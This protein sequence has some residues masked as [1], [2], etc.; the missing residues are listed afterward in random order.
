MLKFNEQIFNKIYILNSLKV[1]EKKMFIIFWQELLS[2][3]VL[4]YLPCFAFLWQC[5][6]FIIILYIVL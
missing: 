3:V 1:F 5:Y 6:Q 4:V 2:V